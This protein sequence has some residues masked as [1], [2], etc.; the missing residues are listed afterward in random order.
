MASPS[1]APVPSRPS[2]ATLARAGLFIA[3][4]LAIATVFVGDRRGR[5]RRRPRRL[6]DLSRRRGHRR[7]PA[8]H[9]G[10]HRHGRRRVRHLQPAVHRAALHPHRRGPARVAQPRPVP[11]RRARHRAAGGD[12]GGPRGGGRVACRRVRG[13]VRDHP[14]P[15]RRRPGRRAAGRRAQPRRRRGDGPRL[16][17]ARGRRRGADG[18]RHGQW[19]VGPAPPVVQVLMADRGEP[20]WV[21]THGAHPGADRRGPDE[22]RRTPG[23]ERR[24]PAGLR[25]GS[26]HRY[27][28]RLE[29]DGAAGRCPVGDARRRPARAVA[30]RDPAAR[31]GRRPGRA[32]R[33]PGAAAPAGPRR[34]GRPP[35][36]GAEE[37]ARRLRVPR[38]AHAARR[39]SRG[40]RHA[41]R[42]RRASA[43]PRRCARRPR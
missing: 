2:A 10:R 36:R 43:R 7:D 17:H 19:T 38:P 33:R 37:R 24:L 3:V 28:V 42:S 29:S 30:W 14:H 25:S 39:H 23:V 13:P 6:A 1:I 40:G 5:G 22:G 15:R 35:R 20:A 9:R 11:V 32:G 18:R 27:K 41:R 26:E 34:R 31:P 12:R 4:V 16:V 21:R 8:A